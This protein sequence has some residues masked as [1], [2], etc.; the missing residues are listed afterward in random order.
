MI[1]TD[2]PQ[3]SG[4]R[5]IRYATKQYLRSAIQHG[6]VSQV[7]VTGDPAA[8]CGAEPDIAIIRIKIEAIFK[9]GRR[10]NQVPARRVCH[11]LRRAG[12]ATRV[13]H[14]QRVFRLDPAYRTF[15]FRV[16]NN[17]RPLEI[18]FRHNID[19][20]YIAVDFRR[21]HDDHLRHNA[22]IFLNRY[23]RDV[24][25]ILQLDALLPPDHVLACDHNFGLGR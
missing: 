10:I 15:L 9:R 6:P 19:I 23:Q 12:T 24:R 22:P 11:T 2:F 20:R 17:F 3:S 8:I 25:Y 1:R 13:Q 7:C 5:V 21:I 4:V 18:S 14:K 16:F